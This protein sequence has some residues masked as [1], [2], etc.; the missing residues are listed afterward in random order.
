MG[1]REQVGSSLELQQATEVK[2]LLTPQPKVSCHH[3]YLPSLLFEQ[4]ADGTLRKRFSLPLCYCLSPVLSL[5]SPAPGQSLQ[6]TLQET[7][8]ACEFFSNSSTVQK[9]IQPC[10]G[11]G[12]CMP[13]CWIKP[14]LHFKLLQIFQLLLEHLKAKACP[15]YC[16]PW[17]TPAH[18]EAGQGNYLENK[19]CLENLLF[20]QVSQAEQSNGDCPH[21]LQIWDTLQLSGKVRL[22]F[23]LAAHRCNHAF[24]LTASA[25]LW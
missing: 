25:F 8:F 10:L 14:L 7:L 18:P 3:H 6:L 12:L 23:A 15:V 17:Q 19:F 21:N 9:G 1:S 11:P 13:C 22:Y 16:S 20:L 2:N 5:S 4:F 24:S